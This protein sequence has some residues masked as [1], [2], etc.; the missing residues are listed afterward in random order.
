MSE[1][2]HGL[3]NPQHLLLCFVV[4]W[5]SSTV[6]TEE[7]TRMALVGFCPSQALGTFQHLCTHFFPFWE[8]SYDKYPRSSD[9]LTS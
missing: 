5:G 1:F 8:C 7:A 3:T 6:I 9:I 2:V 4:V